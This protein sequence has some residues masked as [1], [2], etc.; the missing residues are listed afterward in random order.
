MRARGARIVFLHYT[1]PAILGGVEQVMGAQARELRAL[2]ADVTIVAGRGAA[3]PRGVRLVRVRDVDSLSPA[4]QRDFDRLARGEVT[5][6]HA[7]L[8]ERLVGAMRPH[9]THADRVVVHNVLTMH[10]NLAL[11]EALARLARERRGRFVA[12]THDLAW[13]DPQYGGQLHLRPPWDVI[14][15]AQPRLRYCAVFNDLAR[16]LSPLFPVPRASIPVVPNGVDLAATLGLSAAGAALAERLG[17]FDAD[18]LLLLPARITRRKRVEAAIDATAAL[19][20]RGR[21]AGKDSGLPRGKA[22]HQGRSGHTG[23]CGARGKQTVCP[24]SII[25]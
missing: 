17:L 23:H 16:E 22:R 12:W 5:A 9:V 13:R 25:A 11:S 4:V 7:A 3:A 18:P 14:R 2:G 6:A 8:V 21:G 19:A 20:R 1:S 10:K 24:S 15:S